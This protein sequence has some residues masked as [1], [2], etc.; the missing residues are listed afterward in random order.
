MAISAITLT[1]TTTEQT[2][3]RI[4]DVPDALLDQD[5]NKSVSLSAFSDDELKE[6]GRVWTLALLDRATA[7]RRPDARVT[8]SRPV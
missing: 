8:E 7:I 1:R 6:V 5:T 2:R 3:Y 4:P